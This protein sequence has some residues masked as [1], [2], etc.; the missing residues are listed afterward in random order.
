M[1]PEL[2]LIDTVR[3]SVGAALQALGTAA[4]GYPFY[5]CGAFLALW[6]PL[7]FT[8]R[9]A[10]KKHRA[11]GIAPGAA[12]LTS[13][14]VVAAPLLAIFLVDKLLYLSGV[15]TLESRVLEYFSPRAILA[16]AAAKAP[17][18]VAPAVARIPQLGDPRVYPA[19]GALCVFGTLALGAYLALYGRGG[20]GVSLKGE[21]AGGWMRMA[22]H[23]GNRGAEKRFGLWAQPLARSVLG[24]SAFAAPAAVAGH[25]PPLLWIVALLVTHGWLQAAKDAL[26]PKEPAQE[27]ENKEKEG[28]GAEQPPEGASAAIPAGADTLEGVVSRALA[29][30]CELACAQDAAKP[31]T[32]TCEAA[33]SALFSEL[34]AGMGAGKLFRNQAQAVSAFLGGANVLLCTPPGSGRAAVRDA[35]AM[36]AAL[37]EGVSVLFVCRS[38][39]EAEAAW[40]AFRARSEKAHWR[41]NVPALV[42]SGREQLDL[43]RVQPSIV[44][45]SW[46]DV[47]ARLL[48][49]ASRFGFFLRSLR[50]VSIGGLERYQGPS[51]DHLAYL[52]ARLRRVCAEAAGPASLASKSAGPR[53]LAIADPV[54]PDVVR[55]AERVAAEQVVVIGEEIDGAPAA[56]M[57][58]VWLRRPDGS[59]P[60]ADEVARE[61]DR[62]QTP[63]CAVG[64]DAELGARGAASHPRDARALLV[65]ACA[66]SVAQLP[67]MLRHYGCA[68]GSAVVAFWLASE[69]P[70]SRLLPGAGK[71]LREQLRPPRLVIG[72]GSHRLARDHA[73]CAIAEAEWPVTELEAVFGAEPAREAIEAIKREGPVVVERRPQLDAD[74]S[75]VGSREVARAHKAR[76]HKRL[77]LGIVGHALRVEDR[78]TGRVVLSVPAERALAA[79]YP[80]RIIES[81]AR[82]Y[83]MLP[84]AEQRRREEGVLWAESETR[85]IATVPV[86]RIE[87]EPQPERRRGERRQAERESAGP[88][89]RMPPRRALAGLEFSLSYPRVRIRERIEGFRTVRERA[90]VDAGS[91]PEI[92][93][94]VHDGRAAIL[95]FPS[96]SG[97][98]VTPAGLHALAHLFRAVLPAVLQAG[99]DDLDV[100]D[101]SFGDEPAIAFVDLHP[102]G[103]GY[104]EAV[105]LDAVRA[106]A[107]LSLAVVRGCECR[108]VGGCPSCVRVPE[109]HA[110]TMSGEK[111]PSRREAER[112]LCQLLDPALSASGDAVVYEE[113][114]EG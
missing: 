49:G 45:A 59:V 88:D 96:V 62:T 18:A 14:L 25:I 103:G 100:A 6:V 2:G 109:C 87:I 94:G 28:E 80:E 42:L 107:K 60:S 30:S 69:D 20:V 35:L 54:G 68:S 76:P 90:V 36:H 85:R 89:R 57:R 92:I 43:D 58:H 37:A 65:R 73:A 105:S 38:V 110:P 78:S 1:Q 8:A 39:E 101:L 15:T 12:W 97:W 102:G 7:L 22:G 3:M 53:L 63:W 74:A 71:A 104:A 111:A 72:S 13:A 51:A 106:L 26:A 16:S 21:E 48:A 27:E 70:L 47:H 86:R 31:A 24:I 91:F 4:E 99:P 61:L 114:A 81:G 19:A 9:V 44:F 82:R 5:V 33:S 98:A 34:L 84:V 64:L 11:A 10:T 41:W 66:R 77:A 67:L 23:W 113:D 40:R 93:D 32:E 83:R 79:A 108:K 112:L 95:G 56:A 17:A 52:L 46:E 55:L 50:L 29:A 75:D